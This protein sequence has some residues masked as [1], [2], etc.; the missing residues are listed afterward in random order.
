MPL[1]AQLRGNLI[2]V[3]RVPYDFTD[4]QTGQRQQGVTRLLFVATNHEERP[5]AVKFRA[6]Q[7]DVFTALVERSKI[8]DPI[9]FEVEPGG[10]DNPNQHAYVS[11]VSS[12]VRNAKAVAAA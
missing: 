12:D 11:L 10:R 4:R 3:A 1:T 8:G 5:H 9:A 6:D 7:D 2:H